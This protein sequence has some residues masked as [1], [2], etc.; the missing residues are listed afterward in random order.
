MLRDHQ[1]V[2]QKAVCYVYCAA[3]VSLCNPLHDMRSKR[4]VHPILAQ[5]TSCNRKY[6]V[7]GLLLFQ[8]AGADQLPP[9]TDCLVTIDVLKDYPGS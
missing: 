3:C 7:E 6:A 5:W 1:F 2:C 8:V 4:C 9:E